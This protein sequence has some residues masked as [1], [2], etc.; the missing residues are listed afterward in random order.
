MDANNKKCNRCGKIEIA[1]VHAFRVRSWK[2]FYEPGNFFETLTKENEVGVSGLCRSCDGELR[3]K[4]YDLNSLLK[5][6][7]EYGITTKKRKK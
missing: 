2:S 4:E 6:L 5:L 1:V 7:N 3:K